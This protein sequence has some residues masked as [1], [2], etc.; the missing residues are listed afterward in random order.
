MGIEL[1]PHLRRGHKAKMIGVFQGAKYKE[2]CSM[3]KVGKCKHH[4][5]QFKK[6]GAIWQA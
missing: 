3:Q 5:C 2:E 1:G 4:G 6:Q